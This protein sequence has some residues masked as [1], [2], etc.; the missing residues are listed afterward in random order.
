MG[1]KNVW[2]SKNNI[3]F[4]DIVPECVQLRRE[5]ET[6]LIVIKEV[7]KFEYWR[8]HELNNQSSTLKKKSPHEKIKIK[9]FF[10]ELNSQIKIAD[11]LD[12]EIVDNL[13]SK[14]AQMISFMEV[15]NENYTELK[16]V[17]KKTNEL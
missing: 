16:N 10:E 13:K 12:T 14:K 7:E 17:Q 9:R 5:R 15:A 8:I 4:Q 6:I 1:D 11:N 2:T 3:D